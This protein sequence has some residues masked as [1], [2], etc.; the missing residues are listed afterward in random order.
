MDSSFMGCLRLSNQSTALCLHTPGT[1][2]E[3]TSI[4]ECCSHNC[5][6]EPTGTPTSSQTCG[7]NVCRHLGTSTLQS[8]LS[9]YEH[10]TILVAE[11]AEVRG[12]LAASS[13]NIIFNANILLPH[14]QDRLHGHALNPSAG[15]RRGRAARPAPQWAGLRTPLAGGPLAGRARARPG[16]RPAPPRRR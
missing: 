12:I 15:C 7:L 14:G 6:R 11:L 9:V 5:P 16:G 1:R 10:A 8:N 3:H 4:L 2:A 13:I